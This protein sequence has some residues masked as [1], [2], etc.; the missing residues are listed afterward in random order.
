[1]TSMRAVGQDRY[2]AADGVLHLREVEIP[3]PAADEVMD[4]TRKDVTRL[5][6]PVDLIVDVASTLALS[7]CERILQADGLYIA[8]GHDHYGTKGRRTLGGFPYFLGL[9]ARASFN[10]HLDRSWFEVLEKGDAMEI[11]RGMLEAGG[12]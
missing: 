7:D 11:L 9:M 3:T 6:E 12:N 2:G 10:R 4:Y 5:D 1:M 8:I